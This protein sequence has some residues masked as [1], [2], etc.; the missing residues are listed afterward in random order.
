[1]H[2]LRRD[3]FER[4]RIDTVRGLACALLVAHHCTLSL[5]DYR[6]WDAE[7]VHRVDEMLSYLRMPVFAFISGLILGITSSPIPNTGFVLKKAKRLLVP[8]LAVT[9]ILLVGRAAARGDVTPLDIPYSWIYPH[10][11]MWFLPAAFLFFLASAFFSLVADLRQPRGAIIFLALALCASSLPLP[12][13]LPFAADK[14]AQLAPF[15]ALGIAIAPLRKQASPKHM[16]LVGVVV[17]TFALL[18]FMAGA[19]AS[20]VLIS[21]AVVSAVFLAMPYVRP[22][23]WIGRY[24]F[25]IYLFHGVL[26]SL[27]IRLAPG[28]PMFASAATFLAA[29]LVPV[30]IEMA[31]RRWLPIAMPLIGQER[32][33]PGVS[34]VAA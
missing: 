6:G 24:S 29:L 31:I 5:T 18:L 14:A 4:S 32:P 26:I 9:V 3:I 28:A 1:M 20:R 11:H 21:T 7:T 23:E 13:G 8:F 15:F 17:A 10:S 27:L 34:P 25:S 16:A 33:P 30:A 12:S 2:I 22:L 19:D